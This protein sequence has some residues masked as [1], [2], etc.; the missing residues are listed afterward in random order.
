MSKYETFDKQNALRSLV[1]T[2]LPQTGSHQ[3]A[4][5]R[6]R[7]LRNAEGILSR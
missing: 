7:Q 1:A 3:F 5:A 4:L 6:L 2:K